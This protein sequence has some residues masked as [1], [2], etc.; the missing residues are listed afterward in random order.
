MKVLA[1]G[2]IHTKA[3]IIFAVE[4]L[5]D[6]YDAIVFVGDYA[7][8]WNAPPMRTL[9]TWRY[10]KDFQD[11][12]PDKVHVMMGNHDYIYVNQTPTIAGGYN[13][14]TQFTLNLPDNKDLKNWL[15]N[16]PITLKLDGVTYSHAGLTIFYE[17]GHNLWDDY[18]PIWVRPGDEDYQAIPQVFGHTPS[19]TCWEVEP[20]IWC[21]DTFSTYPDGTLIGDQ[22]VL[23]ITNGKK[24]NKIGL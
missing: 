17:E 8:D 4:K 19:P 10:L 23:E 22:T 20:N 5:I 1:V 16:L 6:K 7:D 21:I 2:D 11:N 13:K 3:E 18:S 12:Y 14:M 24:F 15:S 9:N